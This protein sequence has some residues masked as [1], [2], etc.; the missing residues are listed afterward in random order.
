[1]GRA[2]ETKR[3]RDEAR[4]ARKSDRLRKAAEKFA[5]EREHTAPALRP[6]NKKQQKYLDYLGSRK[7][8]IVNGV[9]GSGKTFM[10]SAL[11]VIFCVR[12]RLIR[13]LLHVLTSR[14]ERLQDLNPEMQCRNC[15]PI[16]EA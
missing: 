15:G 2:K 5:D 4:E 8:I 1:M 9:F 13:S 3:M 7:I 12:T 11:Q 6:M 10:A 14:Q 16:F